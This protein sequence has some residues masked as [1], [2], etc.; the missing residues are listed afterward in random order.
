VY[1]IGK[2]HVESLET[3][4]GRF[5]TS[6]EPGRL[7]VA[8]LTAALIGDSE[9]AATLLDRGAD[10]NFADRTGRTA[11]I[12][13]SF[14]GHASMIRLL[15]ERGAE[16]NAQDVDGWSAL[17][18]AASKGR[19]ELVRI[20]LRYGADSNAASAT[21]WTALRLAAKTNAELTALLKEA[22]THK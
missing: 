19:T 21:G 14:G 12:E 3:S 20:L 5:A 17:M 22:G 7:S 6:L 11:L 8:L 13:A 1:A 4:L 15:L 18:E 2:S 9:A 10:V 16:V